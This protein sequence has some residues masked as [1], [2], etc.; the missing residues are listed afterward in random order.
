MENKVFVGGGGAEYG[1]KQGL[2]LKYANRHGL[3]AGAT[4][5]GKTV[6]LQ[7]LAEGFSAA[8]VPVFLSDV[9]G[10]LSG[11]ASAGSENFKLHKAFMDRC[12]TIGFDDYTYN[13]FPVI[14][15]DLF[16]KAGHPVRATVAEMGPLLLSRLMQLSE[17]QEGVMNIAFRVADE[18]GLPLLDLKDLQSL[19]V[20]VGQNSADLSLRYGNVSPQSV[21]AIQRALLVLE[22]QGGAAFF[23]EPA[24]ALEDLMQR[25]PDGR[26]QINILAA[27]KLMGAPRLYATF[28][29]WLLSELFETLPEVGDPDKPKLV[30]FFDEAHLLF[31]D[32]PKALVD[33]VE[34]VARLIRS[35]GV[36]VY[37]I[38]QN[39]DDVPEDILGQLGNRVQHALRAFTARDRKALDR[40]AETY[41]PNDRFDTADAIRDVGV[42]E[43]V[44]SMLEDKGVPGIV[45][46]T[47]IR[48]PSSKLGPI[49]DATRRQVLATS[50]LAG[51]YETALDRQ[52]AFE[53][54]QKRADDAARA[55]EEAEAKA[56]E[57]SAAEREFNAGRRYSGSK[58]G[59]STSRSSRRNPSFGQA[60]ASVVIKE[61][62]GTTGRR[63]V[64]GIL[65]GLFK[66][67]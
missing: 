18:E 58:V 19:L 23:G 52:S 49:D 21:G 32:A 1:E 9:K 27:D 8:G 12:A 47:L 35:K 16:G 45:E 55:A 53:M 50:P 61:L 17:A 63:I 66:G 41:R 15:W 37:F 43:A 51:K 25:A 22:N 62:K 7:I 36:G 57:Q 64:R 6:T 11:L 39:P 2:S 56:E 42:G 38:T 34:Q 26:G 3:I 67:R 4:G 24:L 30:F 59:R 28:L 48:P 5:T 14:F 40:A 20:W 10:D 44:T 60:V 54:L 65:G 31:E 46:R 29:L 33:K 13:D